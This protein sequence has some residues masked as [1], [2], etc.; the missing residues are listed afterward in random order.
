MLPLSDWVDRRSLRGSLSKLKGSEVL[1]TAC[2]EA[3]L[4]NPDQRM[5]SNSAQA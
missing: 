5:A 4:K 3:Q 2:K 1:Q